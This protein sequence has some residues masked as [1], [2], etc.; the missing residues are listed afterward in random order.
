MSDGEFTFIIDISTSKSI[1]CHCF[2][3]Q[4]YFRLFLQKSTWT[5]RSSFLVE[6][7][8]AVFLQ[9]KCPGTL[10]IRKE[11]HLEFMVC[12]SWE[13]LTSNQFPL[14]YNQ[15]FSRVSYTLEG[16]AVNTCQNKVEF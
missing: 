12:F 14:S 15:V 11:H 2:N 6:R 13:W 5:N 1:S 10:A 9:S 3:M 7:N 16:D 4:P 8:I